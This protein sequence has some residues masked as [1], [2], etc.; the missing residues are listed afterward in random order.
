MTQQPDGSTPPKQKG[1]VPYRIERRTKHKRG[2]KP[3][4]VNAR[5]GPIRVP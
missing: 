2:D 4:N 1:G 3:A 5:T